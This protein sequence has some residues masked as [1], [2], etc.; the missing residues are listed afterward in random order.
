MWC[1]GHYYMLQSDFAYPDPRYCWQQPTNAPGP[2]AVRAEMKRIIQFWF[3]LGADGFR[4]DMALSLVKGDLDG[5]A[6]RNVC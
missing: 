1:P 5:R 2:R 4:A 3:D 6:F